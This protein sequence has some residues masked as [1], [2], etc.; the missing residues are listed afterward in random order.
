MEQIAFT[1]GSYDIEPP[2]G[3]PTGGLGFL[4]IL[5]SNFLTVFIVAG[6][7]IMVM[8]IIYAGIQWITSR[9]DKQK[10]ATARGRL[11]FAIVGFLIILTATFVVN[12]VGFFFR[13]ELLKFD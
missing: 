13:V 7:I 10:L 12:L 4:S 5:L 9:G 1:F 11:T 2:D 6:G 3:I 8:Y